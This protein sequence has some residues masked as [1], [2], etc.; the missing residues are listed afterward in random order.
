MQIRAV[1]RSRCGMSERNGV[2]K[3]GCTYHMPSVRGGERIEIESSGDRTR[4]SPEESLVEAVV[5]ASRRVNIVRASVRRRRMD[6]ERK[7]SQKGIHRRETHSSHRWRVYRTCD[8]ADRVRP[9]ALTHDKTLSEGCGE[10]AYVRPQDCDEE[11]KCEAAPRQPSTSLR[12]RR[13]T[14]Q[15]QQPLSEF[16]ESLLLTF[17]GYA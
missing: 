6:P 13:T 1:V 11:A 5:I 12:V 10:I 4:A 16:D 14:L 8:W 3:Y 15:S 9:V 7:F 2:E 17:C